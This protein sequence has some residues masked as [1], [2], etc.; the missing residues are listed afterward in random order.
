FGCQCQYLFDARC[1]G[2]VPDH[3]CLRMR[4]DMLLH[5]HAN[6]LQIESHLLQ[7]IDGYALSNFD[8]AEQKVFRSHVVVAQPLSLLARKRQDLL[9]TWSKIIHQRD[10]EARP[11]LVETF[12][13]TSALRH[14][15]S[16]LQEIE[17]CYNIHRV[18]SKK[19]LI[20]GREVHCA[21][22]GTAVVNTSLANNE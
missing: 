6:P 22:K 10:S 12:D 19:N 5:L 2:K 3:V 1:V 21:P 18:L 15:P 7:H 13:T 9:G 8:Q 20:A 17:Y 11:N 16:K 14:L 4:T